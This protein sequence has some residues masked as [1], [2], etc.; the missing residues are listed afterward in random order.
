[1]LL[2]RANLTHL[3]M[4]FGD[5]YDGVQSFGRPLQ[6]SDDDLRVGESLKVITILFG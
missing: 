1:L 2:G 5:K 4:K 6:V 3:I